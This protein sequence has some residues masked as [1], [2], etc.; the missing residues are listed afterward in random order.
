M[1][2]DE[3][4]NDP[5]DAVLGGKSKICGDNALRQAVLAGTLGVIRRR[6]RLK[7][8]SM[9]A[10]LLGCYLAGMATLAVWHQGGQQKNI[11]NQSIDRVAGKE[12][13]NTEVKQ[14]LPPDV[15]GPPDQKAVYKVASKYE[16]L[17]R[18]A[19]GYLSDPEKLHLA[20]SKYTQALKHASADQRAISPEHD[21]WLLM[22]L[23]DAQS[24]KGGQSYPSKEIRHENS[25]L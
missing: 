14:T 21:T 10:A 25:Q 6:R 19:D 4:Q 1:L 8:C 12:Q 23:K 2:S 5:L 18:Q 16:V 7:R 9:A 24:K 17:C 11:S 20:V 3:S 13:P 22:A 15:A